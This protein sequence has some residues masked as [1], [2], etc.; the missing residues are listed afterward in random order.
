MNR[1][2]ILR[3]AAL[4]IAVAGVAAVLAGA[5]AGA[6]PP[7]PVVAEVAGAAPQVMEVAGKAGGALGPEWGDYAGDPVSFEVGARAVD[8]L[9][10][11]G[12]FHVV[13]RKPDGRLLAEF[14][15]KVTSLYAVD[16]VATLTGVIEQADHPGLPLEMVGQKIAL[17]VYDSG[18]PP[19]SAPRT[20]DRIGWAWGFFGAPV[21]RVQGTAP[22]FAV[23][24]GDFR[25]ESGSGQQSSA[26]RVD[27]KSDAAGSQIHAVLGGTS[28][29]PPFVGDPLRFAL[30]A[31]IAPGDNALQVK[32]GFHVTH[33]KPDGQVVADFQGRI[34]C[35]A[36]GGPVAVATGVVT[37]STSAPQLVGKPVSFSL[38][39]GRTDRLGWLWGFTPTDEPI[40]D[41]QSITPFY[42]PD[43][44]GLSVR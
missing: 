41:C 10:P 4:G 17:T 27:V 30:A 6:S 2:R 28:K 29:S 23:S 8:P 33:H 9:N 12:T 24:W 36:V 16:E 1:R 26:A 11:T 31:R 7:T 3:A 35:L 20:P 5:S 32:G 38:K 42:A 43:W 19:G 37:K 44:G 14:S 15:G 21:S 25:V 18:R 40:N 39:D 22:H 34:T 13:H